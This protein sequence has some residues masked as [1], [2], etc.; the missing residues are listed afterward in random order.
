MRLRIARE[1]IEPERSHT[2]TLRDGRRLG[3]AEWG[4]PTGVAVV[5]FHGMPGSRLETHASNTEY[6]DLGVH[7]VTVDRP[8]YG[9]SDRSPRRRLLDWPEDVLELTD[10]LG[11]ERF[12]LTAL[13]GGGPFALALARRYPER[14]LGVAIAGCLAPLD[15]AWAYRG[16]KRLDRF[17]LVLARR[18]PWALTVGYRAL[19]V[20]LDRSPDVF[21]MA[22]THDKPDADQLWLHQPEVRTRLEAMLVEAVRGG[23]LGAVQEVGLLARPWGFR[24]EDIA[25]PVDLYHGDRDDT[26][27]LAHARYLAEAIPRARLHVCP[28]EGHMVMWSHVGA[29]LSAATGRD[30]AHAAGMAAGL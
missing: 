28:G 5:H 3:Y 7:L 2:I 24:L 20:L 23:V 6:A 22:M 4:D 8:G 30:L 12:G 16:I 27:P 13:S 25:I 1:N 26:A 18:A 15:G 9:L 21:L 29:M 17:G 10:A 14:L 19:R 11:I